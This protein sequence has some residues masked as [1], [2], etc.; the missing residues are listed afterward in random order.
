MVFMGL[1]EGS[2]GRQ[3]L[4]LQISILKQSVK[5]SEAAWTK[6]KFDGVPN[7]VADSL[8]QQIAEKERYLADEDSHTSP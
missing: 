4:I 2:N 3:G 7:P 1:H 8:R 5:V 6:Y